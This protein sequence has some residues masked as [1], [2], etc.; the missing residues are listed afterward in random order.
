MKT[1]ITARNHSKLTRVVGSMLCAAAAT[2]CGVDLGDEAP[3][4]ESVDETEQ[5]I[6]EPGCA[7][8]APIVTYTGFV[9]APG[10]TSPQAYDPVGCDKARSIQI[11]NYSPSYVGAGDVGGTS[12]SW[13]DMFPT[14]QSA[15]QAAWVRADLYRQIAGTWTFVASK[16]ANGLW[17][18]FFGTWQCHSLS[19]QYRNKDDHPDLLM[20][21]SNYRIVSTARTSV[22]GATRKFLVESTKDQWIK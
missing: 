7:T 16:Q 19:V 12:V 6:G 9:P 17:S 21:G 4:L 14:T 20:A 13:A 1:M 3:E 10:Y 8:M 15:C 18:N 11:D 22:G 5:A 2:A